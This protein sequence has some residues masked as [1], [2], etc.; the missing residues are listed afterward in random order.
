[1]EKAGKANNADTLARLL[2]QFDLEMAR[3]NAYLLYSRGRHGH[4]E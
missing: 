1:M 3:V 2:P 4:E